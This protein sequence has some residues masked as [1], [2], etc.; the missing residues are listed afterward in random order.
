[1][2]MMRGVLGGDAEVGVIAAVTPA[3][4]ARPLAILVTPEI[5]A[6]L[7]LPSNLDADE[8]VGSIGGDEVTVLLDTVGGQRQP[9]ALRVNAWIFH[10]LTI[11]ARKLWSRRAP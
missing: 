10:N 6:E 3:G 7:D 2:A 5:G 11:F 1:M 4:V 9:V 8:V